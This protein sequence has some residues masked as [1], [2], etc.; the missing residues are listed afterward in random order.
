MTRER[1]SAGDT[2][3]KRPAHHW[4]TDGHIGGHA[5]YCANPSHSLMYYCRAEYDDQ[6]RIAMVSDAWKRDHPSNA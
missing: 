2:I 3:G 5:P 1:D 6:G 4:D